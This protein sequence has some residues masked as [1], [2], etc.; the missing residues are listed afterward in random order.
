MSIKSF[1]EGMLMPKEKDVCGY[2]MRGNVLLN[3]HGIP[4]ETVEVPNYVNEYVRGMRQRTCDRFF[5]VPK[6]RIEVPFGTTVIAANALADTVCTSLTLPY[7]VKRIGRGAFR[8]TEIEDLY[9]PE[10]VEEIN[11]YAF[12]GCKKLKSIRFAKKCKLRRIGRGAFA[13]TSLESVVIPATV[14]EIG[15]NAFAK[16]NCLETFIAGEGEPVHFEM[17]TRGGIG[18]RSEKL[19]YV[20]LRRITDIPDGSLDQMLDVVN[21]KRGHY[22][23]LINPTSISSTYKGQ[24]A[25][26]PDWRA[27][28]QR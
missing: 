18:I 2:A 16:N 7:T 28:F 24:L 13:G 19:D 21:K 14:T 12:F 3:A 27:I 8:N 15:A 4:I 5:V 17:N 10:G 23:L 6:R 20:D 25:S 9:I 22:T 26:D 11:D 1:V